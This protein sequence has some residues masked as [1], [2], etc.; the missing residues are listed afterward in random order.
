MDQTSCITP[1]QNSMHYTWA[2]L[3]E[4][5]LGHTACTTPGPHFFHYKWPDPCT[6]H[7]Q[8]DWAILHALSLVHYLPALHLVPTPCSTPGP[9]STARSWHL[10]HWQEEVQWSRRQQWQQAT[11]QDRGHYSVKGRRV[12][13]S[14]MPIQLD[15]V[16]PVD[17]RPSTD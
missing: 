5:D 11:V 14:V 12:L 13:C 3:P 15:G 17:N 9:D 6:T 4:L 1:R 16:G 7:G 10:H 2:T 8:Y